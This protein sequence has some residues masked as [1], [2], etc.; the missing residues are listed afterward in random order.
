[1]ILFKRTAII[2]LMLALAIWFLGAN[3]VFSVKDD[4]VD[5]VLSSPTS[6][7][8]KLIEQGMTEASGIIEML[9]DGDFEAAMKA[10]HSL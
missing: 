8:L 7:E 3:K 9:V 10:L 4:V 1:M 2:L 6:S 5:F